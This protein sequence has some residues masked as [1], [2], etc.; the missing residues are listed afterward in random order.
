MT[1]RNGV[2][3]IKLEGELKDGTINDFANS[4]RSLVALALA[5]MHACNGICNFYYQSLIN[6]YT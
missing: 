1:K 3:K 4:S 6:M 2:T 5:C